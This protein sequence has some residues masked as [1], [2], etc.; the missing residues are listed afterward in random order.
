MW[1]FWPFSYF[2]VLLIVHIFLCTLFLFILPT[3]DC[4]SLFGGGTLFPPAGLFRPHARGLQKEDGR[5]QRQKWSERQEEEEAML[6]PLRRKLFYKNLKNKES[7]M[8]QRRRKRKETTTGWFL[9]A[10]GSDVTQLHT[11]S[12]NTLSLSA[13]RKNS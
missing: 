6:H 13:D 4:W 12:L 7:K 3:S 8:K 1:W 11:K 2:K 5:E 9:G 10:S